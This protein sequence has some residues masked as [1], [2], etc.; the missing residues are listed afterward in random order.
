VIKPIKNKIKLVIANFNRNKFG[1]SDQIATIMIKGIDNA[2][3]IVRKDNKISNLDFIINFF[4]GG[5]GFE[6]IC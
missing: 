6:P 2:N 3:I 5:I 1:I 4:K